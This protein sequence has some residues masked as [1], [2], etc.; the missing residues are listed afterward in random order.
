MYVLAAHLKTA[1]DEKA[2]F[3]LA[4]TSGFAALSIETF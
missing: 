4:E 1:F 3:E 2:T